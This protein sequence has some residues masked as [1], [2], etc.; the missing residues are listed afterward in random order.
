[1]N[2]K[3]ACLCLISL[4]FRYYLWDIIY[5]IKRIE[6][7]N[8]LFSMSFAIDSVTVDLVFKLHSDSVRVT[9]TGWQWPGDTVM[10]RFIWAYSRIIEWIFTMIIIFKRSVNESRF[11][12]ILEKWCICL[13]K[14]LDSLRMN[15]LLVL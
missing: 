7:L 13:S 3:T 8:C 10:N 4:I 15:P 12:V 2:S 6:S 5:I 9:V 14:K 11:M 1:M